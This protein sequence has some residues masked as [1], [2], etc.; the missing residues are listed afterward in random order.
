MPLLL[1]SCTHPSAQLPGPSPLKAPSVIGLHPYFRALR[2]VAVVIG[3]EKLHFLFDTGAGHT[4]LSIQQAAAFGCTPFGRQV[5]HRMNGEEVEFRWC[6]RLDFTLNGVPAHHEPVAVFDL[7][8]LLPP[9]LP[10][11]AGVLSL[12][13]LRG[14]AVTLDWPRNELTVHSPSS[15]VA[16]L[17]ASGVPARL[18]TGDD[19]ATLTILVPVAGGRGTLWFLLDSGSIAGTVVGQHVV[20]DGLLVVAPDSTVMMT[21]SPRRRVQLPV[22][23]APIN[24]D[25]VFGTDFLGQGRVTLDLRN[26]P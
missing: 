14:Y 20:R 8:A 7:L 1:C 4:L 25:G 17:D 26:F 13:S 23:V 10:R 18:A 11:L 19:G 2:T 12:Q 22:R 5:G 15:A 3:S 16:A 6:A 21:I 9:P 24:Y